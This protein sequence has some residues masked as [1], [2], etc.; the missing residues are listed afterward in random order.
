MT[1]FDRVEK[2]EIRLAV[3]GKFPDILA[4]ARWVN[5]AVG[6]LG[7]LVFGGFLFAADPATSDDTLPLA[8]QAAQIA[9]SSPTSAQLVARDTAIIPHSR[10]K[11]EPTPTS[12]IDLLGAVLGASLGLA[13]GLI[14]VCLGVRHA[15]ALTRAEESIDGVGI[16]L[17]AL[18][19]GPT[20]DRMYD[21][22]RLVP[23][24]LRCAAFPATKSSLLRL[25]EVHPDEGRALN[26]LEQITDRRYNSLHDLITEIHVD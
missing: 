15:Q 17:M 3:G 7:A 16:D 11:Q 8:R 2:S 20:C 10:P 13:G 12:M 21:E 26:R 18:P 24:Y 14:G 22:T 23:A 4:L 6:V 1:G 25:A 5:P 9:P 19:R